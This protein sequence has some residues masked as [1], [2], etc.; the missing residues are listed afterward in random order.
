MARRN[1]LAPAVRAFTRIAAAGT[2]LL[3]ALGI[4]LL[5]WL[6]TEGGN[7]FLL[8]TLLPLI[9]PPKGQIELQ[10]LRTDLFSELELGGLKIRDLQGQELLAISSLKAHYR[11]GSLPSLLVVNSLDVEGVTG[12]LHWNQK[13]GLDLVNLW[14][15][16]DPDAPPT[17]LPLDLQVERIHVGLEHFGL[18]LPD[19]DF[20]VE[21]VSL[22]TA[23]EASK[24]SG[25]LSGLKLH[26]GGFTPELGVLDLDGA[27]SLADGRAIRVDR[28]EGTL[29]AQSFA[30][31]GTVG[32]LAGIGHLDL[33][34]LSLKVDPT[35]LPPP[36]AALEPYHL[37]G[38]LLLSGAISGNYQAPKANLL[39]DTPAGQLIT[40][41][42]LDQNRW[43]A[44]FSSPSFALASLSDRLPTVAIS[45]GGSVHG[46]G[47]RPE[48][49]LADADF[50]GTVAGIPSLGP[51]S[52]KV[53]AALRGDT[54]SLSRAD[55][56]GRGLTTSVNGS[57][58]LK[59]QSGA[60]GVRRCV[61]SLDQVRE[62]PRMLSVVPDLP[63]EIRESLAPLA[64]VRMEGTADWQGSVSRG[65]NGRLTAK[66]ILD[67]RDFS[68]PPDVSV[69][70]LGGPVSLDFGAGLADP[71][72]FGPEVLQQVLADAHLEYQGLR[73]QKQTSDRGKLNAVLDP[74]GARWEVQA[75]DRDGES[76]ASTGMLTRKSGYL[77]VETLRARLPQ[78][79]GYLHV[80]GR[81]SGHLHGRN[82]QTIGV[83]DLDFR[84]SGGEGALTA[85]GD[86]GMT[87]P[88]EMDVHATHLNPAILSALAP[89]A[90]WSGWV[91]LSA[92]L[93]GTLSA[94]VFSAEVGVQDLAIPEN[95]KDLDLTATAHGTGESLH[96][97]GS[98]SE[99]LLTFSG[100][101]P[102]SLKPMGLKSDAP[103]K[104]NLK[105][106]PARSSRWEDVLVAELPLLT[107]SG[108][109]DVAGTMAEP[110][111]KV[112]S[113]SLVSPGSQKERLQVDLDARLENRQFQVEG[114]IWERAM[115][116][117][118][119]SGK[120]PFDTRTLMQRLL[121]GQAPNLNEMVAL[122]G[123]PDVNVTA[124]KL[125][126]SYLTEA[127]G[128][129]LDVK[130]VVAGTMHMG[131]SVKEPMLKGSFFLDSAKLGRVEI[132]PAL[133][134]VDT[135]PG[136]FKLVLDAGF[137][138]TGDIHVDGFVP[139]FLNFS[140]P[141][142]VEEVLTQQGLDLKMYGRGLP[143]DLLG[144]PVPG[145][146]N[147]KGNLSLNGR[148]KGAV[149]NPDPELSLSLKDG[150][151]SLEQTGV[152][153]EKIAVE[154]TF[155]HKAI[156]V[157]R[158]SMDTSPEAIED[159]TGDRQTSH[160]EA[161]LSATRGEDLFP[162]DLTGDLKLEGFRLTA[163][164]DRA[165]RVTGATHVGMKNGEILLT[166]NVAVDR[167]L[168]RLRPDFFAESHELELHPDIHV[169]G[170]TPKTYGGRGGI[171][172]ML[173]QIPTWFKASV[174]VDLGENLYGTV[175][176]P[177]EDRFGKLGREFSTV[178]V[179]GEVSGKVK[180]EASH[181]SLALIGAL[182][183]QRGQARVLGKTFTVK[184]GAISFTGTDFMSPLVEVNALFPTAN[185]GDMQVHIS[186]TVTKPTVQFSS[187]RYSEADVLSIILT[188]H[189]SSEEGSAASQL[190]ETAT[191]AVMSL[192]QDRLGEGTGTGLVESVQLDT[193]GVQG[194]FKVSNRITIYT[195]YNFANQS[196]GK[197][198]L[199]VTLEW[200]LPKDWSLEITGGGNG[201]SISALRTWKF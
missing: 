115:P 146:S 55:L 19:Q 82:A 2:L 175:A 110:E 94:P 101:I 84:L 148:I 186:G 37:T 185:Y 193:M 100:D 25:S 32:D 144:T 23:L 143:L 107:A 47:F 21:Q 158:V 174:N 152:R 165:I 48:D 51:L 88:V 188:G 53:A 75:D 160:L 167:A 50:E 125:P 95:L 128:Q 99:D 11:L 85:V 58:N 199:E 177:L 162:S 129:K 168:L 171:K 10:H 123:T 145:F 73:V 39:I 155:L 40:D 172:G 86:V 60:F 31:A 83:S 126:L 106:A 147:G 105:M 138:D 159:L 65:D 72:P 114:V 52:V 18:H 74:E 29:G 3:S 79:E 57:L 62:V 49:L 33:A 164:P 134:Q 124:R 163:L 80:T 28:L 180:M 139:F 194:G 111:I 133:V 154:A 90:D 196:A 4:L 118:M 63:P 13:D 198:P 102:I 12:D 24:R 89:T 96:V 14:G 201:Q 104:L 200:S 61:L 140:K 153:Y 142:S 91:D 184:E 7:R 189:P 17:S 195:R 76:V 68:L 181:S 190:V 150:A 5:V 113:T 116:R 42:S 135:A 173:D 26:V 122:L 77:V 182:K 161:T 35:Q 34:L 178:K 16:S 98:I 130:G 41:L 78:K 119:V 54:L 30:L 66:G 132:R 97:E 157:S 187:D 108:T 131:G 179:E 120:I 1:L 169:L 149:L 67:L 20:A 166:G 127:A 36:L 136:G 70:H 87:G 59:N 45:G 69:A 92:R 176:L 197:V 44:T 117:G 64:E 8:Q 112:V 9:Q 56:A 137:D 141:I 71:S 156:Q 15:P 103:L 93:T 43:A 183:P 38:P 109:I 121:A 6:R 27:G 191:S 81:G 170:T 192:V 22:E 151:F 46:E